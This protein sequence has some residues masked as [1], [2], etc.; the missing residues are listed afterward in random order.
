MTKSHVERMVNKEKD[1]SSAGEANA[2]C[3]MALSSGS[4]TGVSGCA[5]YVCWRG[6]LTIQGKCWVH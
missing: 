4:N 5:T 3:P 1:G 2:G 6:K